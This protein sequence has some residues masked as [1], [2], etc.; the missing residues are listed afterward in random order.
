MDYKVHPLNFFLIRLITRINVFDKIIKT[1]NERGMS[2]KHTWIAGF[3]L[4][5]CACVCV[6][7]LMVH[8]LPLFI[9]IISTLQTPF[10]KTSCIFRIM[11]PVTMGTGGH[12][13]VT[14]D[15]ARRPVQ[16]KIPPFSQ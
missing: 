1:T 7:V 14:T 15:G 6:C 12:T 10:E 11:V 16:N 5:G 4:C 13:S 8:V 9:T 3:I 2:M